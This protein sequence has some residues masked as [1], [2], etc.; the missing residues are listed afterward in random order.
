M[1][2]LLVAEIGALATAAERE[3]AVQRPLSLESIRRF[4]STLAVRA[5]LIKQP[6]ELVASKMGRTGQQALSPC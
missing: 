6:L 5:L 3:G 2:G 1:T 4:L